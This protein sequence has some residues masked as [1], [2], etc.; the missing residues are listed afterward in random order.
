MPKLL[1][2]HLWRKYPNIHITYEAAPINKVATFHC[3]QTTMMTMMQDDDNNND[4]T[5]FGLISQRLLRMKKNVGARQFEIC[6]LKDTRGNT[7]PIYHIQQ[8]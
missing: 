8:V 3:T 7:N 6:Y 2:V 5:A 4:A 1:D